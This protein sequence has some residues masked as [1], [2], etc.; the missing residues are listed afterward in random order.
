MYRV[1]AEAFGEY[2]FKVSSKDA[3]IT[4]DAKSGAMTPPDT[5]LAGLASCVGVYIRKYADGSKLPIGGFTVEVTSDLGNSAPYAFR[6]ISVAV[7]LKGAGLDEKRMA[8][9]L[10]FVK[11]CPIHNTLKI[12]PS[13]NI[14]ITT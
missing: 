6:N 2:R 13:V 1:V 11:N 8:S 9:L 5:F 3:E 12:G 14:T 4:V 7:D 10:E